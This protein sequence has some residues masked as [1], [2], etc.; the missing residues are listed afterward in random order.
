MDVYKDANVLEVLNE[1]LG[2][3]VAFIRLLV[4]SIQA[5]STVT[6][7]R[8]LDLVEIYIET[9]Q[10]VL[11]TLCISNLKTICGYTGIEFHTETV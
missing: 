9:F 2:L 3:A 1:C 10:T 5:D 7:R 11:D 8:V 6:T 4:F